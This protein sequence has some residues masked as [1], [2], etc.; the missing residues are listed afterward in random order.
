MTYD[1]QG[2]LTART[3]P[4]GRTTRFT[5][6]QNR[7]ASMTDPA[8]RVT[9]WT[10][11]AGG[12]VTSTTALGL[13][14]SATYTARGLVATATD[15]D[16]IVTTFGYDA[17]GRLTS[18]SRPGEPSVTIA[19]TAVAGGERIVVT[20]G[21]ESWTVVQDHYR[22]VTSET[23]SRGLAATHTYDPVTG[24]RDSTTETF[25]GQTQTTQRTFT[26]TGD[27]SQVWINGQQRQSA[28]RTVPPGD[29]WLQP[30]SLQ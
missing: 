25:R 2:N 15:A 3:D 30:G 10:R 18:R 5:Y 19:R 6:A 7:L 9:T 16:G 13:T 4:A 27:D 21:G 23:S 20:R 22:R 14:T 17:A 28:P 24:L 8:G 12:L 26:N 1:T 29:V 11:D